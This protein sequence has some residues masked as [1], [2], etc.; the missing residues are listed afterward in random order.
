MRPRA[1]AH[2]EA[3]EWREYKMVLLVADEDKSL[4]HVVGELHEA[5][6]CLCTGSVEAGN[7]DG[8]VALEVRDRDRE[9]V[10]GVAFGAGVCWG[11]EERC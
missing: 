11:V 3:H 1:L 8:Q 5:F 4:G 7:V 9:W 10:G 2:S 6:H